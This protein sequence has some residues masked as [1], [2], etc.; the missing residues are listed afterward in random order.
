M[1]HFALLLVVLTSCAPRMVSVPPPPLNLEDESTSRDALKEAIRETIASHRGEVVAC[2]EETRR[3][4]RST[5]EGKLVVRF[6]IQTD[7]TVSSPN[8]QTS[9]VQ[10]QM[11]ERCVL[12]RLSTWLFPRQQPPGVVVVAY[13]FIFKRAPADPPAK[14]PP[15]Q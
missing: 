10:S 7:G 13:P 2:Y 6:T 1:R 5:P 9:T 8:V 11:F 15:T 12:D 14:H 3:A 4:R